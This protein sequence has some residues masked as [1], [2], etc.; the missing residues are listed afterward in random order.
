VSLLVISPD[1]ASH[2]LPLLAIAGAWRR[3]GHR[4]VVATGHAVAPLVAAAGMEHITLSMSRGSNQGVIAAREVPPEEAASL[5]A[6]IAATREGMLATLRYQAQARA[7]DLLWRP[8]EVAMRTIRI[9]EDVRP[10]AILVDHLAFAATIGL[11]ALGVPYGDV[12]LGHPTALPVGGEVYGVP[13]AW[14]VAITA[15][16]LELRSLRAIARGVSEAFSQAYSDVLRS[17]SPASDGLADAFA[18][19]GDLVLFNYPAEL[20]GPE[21]TALLP[22]H[23]FLGSAVRAERPDPETA[24]WLARPDDRPLVVV[25]LGTFLSARHDVLLRVAAA[26]RRVDVRVAIAIGANDPDLLGAV[27][28]HWLVRAS[29]PQVALLAHAALLVTHAGNNSVT[30]ALTFGVPMLVLPF[31]TDQFDGAAA[32]ERRVAGLAL[33]PNAS[34]R[35]LIAG[36][37]RGLLRNPPSLPALTAQRLRSR[38]GP[39][40]AYE[41]MTNGAPRPRDHGRSD[42]LGEGPERWTVE[43]ATRA[44][45]L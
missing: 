14:P 7:T 36:S 5:A 27:P 44:P 32:V 2:A 30:E 34:P 31:S 43:P 8:R 12:V 45:R 20:H 26:L 23:V 25:S 4:V 33:D 41:A 19:H 38:P 37:V 17:I 10:D 1:Y 11:R 6:F 35:P 15:N 40:V 42:A 18:A 24:A 39:E 9:V 3:R 21:R 28:P 16:A 29:L 22:R 13:S